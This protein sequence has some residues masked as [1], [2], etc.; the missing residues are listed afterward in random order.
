MEVVGD[1]VVA[2]GP[3]SRPDTVN[4]S[5]LCVRGYFAH[6]FLNTAGRLTQ[7]LIRR[8]GHLEPASWDEALD[9]V[10]ETL[11]TLKKKHG[12]GS[13]GFWGSPKCT[14]E[15]NYLFQK[16]ARAIVGSSNIDNSGHWAGQSYWRRVDDRTG[17]GCR[18]QPFAGLEGVDAILVLGAD[19]SQ[20]LPV[21][22]YHIKRGVRN[23][24][25]L[26]NVG[27]V[28]T[29]LDRF[30]A[31]AIRL[32]PERHLLF[33]LG[34]C[35]RMLRIDAIDPAYIADNTEGFDRFRQALLSIDADSL[36]TDD[37]YLEKMVTEAADL[38]KGRRIAAIVGHGAADQ[39]RGDACL[40]ML[41]NLLLM[42]G[43]LGKPGAGLYVE[44]LDNNA[45]GAW[46]MG[47]VPNTL[48]DGNF[49]D[50]RTML[51]NGAQSRPDRRSSDSGLNLDQMIEA[52]EK[53]RLKGLFILG[54]NP[55]RALPGRQRI[56]TA[57]GRL[58]FIVVQDILNQ[59]T[60][61]L[62]HVV[63]PGTPFSEKAGSFTN[64][65]GRIQS[66]VPVVPPLAQSRPD[67]DIL[68]ALA[69]RM[70]GTRHPPTLETIRSEIRRQVPMYA[71]LNN[72]SG[73]GW[74]R[75]QMLKRAFHTEVQGDAMA[76]AS[77]DA[78]EPAPVAEASY[79]YRAVLAVSRFHAG[80]GT[81]TSLSPRIQQSGPNGAIRISPQDCRRIG[82]DPGGRVRVT[83]AHGRLE[84]EM[85]VDPELV[86]GT[87]VVPLGFNANDARQL[88]A[89]NAS[90][91]VLRVN[92]ERMS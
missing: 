18:R 3:A 92:V 30:A 7:P 28:S 55:L 39:E 58:E 17:G 45:I 86:P 88:A 1:Q 32:P 41:I 46:D 90:G 66:F 74:V 44:S 21:L 53:G 10:A 61:D 8:A 78:V 47:A 73:H 33:M 57:L 54:E 59:E 50:G 65:E 56:K 77:V 82:V 48:S 60:V 40:N 22:S 85:V 15:E 72:F 36:T 68:A 2:A 79:P 83:S 49:I 16:I 67:L 51:D 52:A 91:M 43:S 14:N 37:G 42:T 70:D 19:P 13:L 23:G 64:L 20:T 89:P 81:R 11:L 71:D 6:D 76:F 87:L 35:A 27:T 84:R 5:T 24:T 29:E 38:L 25:A 69:A 12:A 62:A 63:L 34:L 26:I 75:P 4:R 80:A 31:M 9:Q